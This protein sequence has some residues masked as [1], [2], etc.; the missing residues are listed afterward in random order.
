M[1]TTHEIEPELAAGP[2]RRVRYTESAL[3]TRHWL[4]NAFAALF[5][6]GLWAAQTSVGFYERLAAVGQT[7]DF[8]TVIDRTE[9]H[10]DGDTYRLQY[11]Y[12]AGG[13]EYGGRAKVREEQYRASP[14]GASCTVLYLPEHPE[15]HFFGADPATKA[16]K[17]RNAWFVVLGMVAVVGGLAVGG[18]QSHVRNRA[19]V[20]ERGDAVKATV[21][22]LRARDDGEGGKTYLVTYRYPL[23]VGGTDTDRVSVSRATFDS[24]REGAAFTLLRYSDGAIER[25]VPYFKVS[26][27]EVIGGRGPRVPLG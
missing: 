4:I 13:A 14:P 8:C 10:G 23:S 12:Q 21:E 3:R 9:S 18:Y 6:V 27:V 16:E 26:E 17:K 24:L 22:S 7:A 5:F 11:T 2:P 20:L 25:T 19:Y 15:R 1:T